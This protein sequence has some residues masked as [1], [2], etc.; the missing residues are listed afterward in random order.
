MVIIV[1]VWLFSFS[2]NLKEQKASKNSENSGIP[3]LFQTLKKDFSSFKE[4]MEAAVKNIN[5]TENEK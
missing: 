5:S 4:S 3:S 2:H 1:V